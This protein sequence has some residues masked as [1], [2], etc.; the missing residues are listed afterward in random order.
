MA[1]VQ[2]YND[3]KVLLYEASER[4][5]EKV[6]FAM[7]ITM[8]SKFLDSSRPITEKQCAFILDAEHTSLFEHVWFTFI[9]T[10]ISRSFLGQITR[11]RIASPTSGSQHY[12]DYSDYPCA[13]SQRLL[14]VPDGII[15]DPET[16]LNNAFLTYKGYLDTGVP[17][18]EARQVLPMAATVNYLWTINARSLLH[19]LRHRLCYR[20]CEEMRIFSDR[21]LNVAQDYFPQLFNRIHRMCWMDGRCKQ[22][23]LRPKDC[24]GYIALN[25]GEADNWNLQ[26]FL[27]K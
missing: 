18:E 4:P 2:T 10:G 20:N 13:I 15:I 1:R 25:S 9:I 24:P 11:Q 26:T 12:Q 19:F 17:R 3:M 6:H 14:D 7:T 27:T 21:V 22:G 16:A 23:H 5:A 8:S